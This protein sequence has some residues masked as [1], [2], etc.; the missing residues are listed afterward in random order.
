MLANYYFEIKLLHM[1]CAALSFL[2]Y[3]TRGFWMLTE[4]RWNDSVWARRVPHWNDALLLTLG[5]LLTTIVQQYP[6]AHGWLTAKLVGLLMHIGLGFV[7]FR[8][9][10]HRGV[11]ISAWIGS[12]LAFG[13]IV[14][15]A[16]THNPWLVL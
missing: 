8:G 14:S 3:T 1:A 5:I 9:P 10:R 6:F 12:L 4:S 16:L 13:Y 11:R 2:L 7:A 15:V